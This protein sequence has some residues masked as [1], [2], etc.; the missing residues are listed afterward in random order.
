M[1]HDGCHQVYCCGKR[2]RR[3]HTT[4]LMNRVLPHTLLTVWCYSSSHKMSLLL[5]ICM[6]KKTCVCHN[7]NRATL[8][9]TLLPDRSPN[10]GYNRAMEGATQPP[11]RHPLGAGHIRS[12]SDSVPSLLPR[13]PARF[14]E[15]LGIVS[16][17]STI[18]IESFTCRTQ[19]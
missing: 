7:L 14:E 19:S 8:T 4:Q 18:D 6:P 12:R 11:L 16:S 5:Y 17:T 3:Y 10:L 9:T 15:A 1:Y 13:H 2:E